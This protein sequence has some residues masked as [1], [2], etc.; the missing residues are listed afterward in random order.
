MRLN[1]FVKMTSLRRCNGRIESKHL[2]F[3]GNA[4]VPFSLLAVSRE[5]NMEGR[6]GILQ[7][8]LLMLSTRET[9]SWL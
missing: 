6:P 2:S 4:Y 1:V 8:C 5:T 9:A 7:L 3:S